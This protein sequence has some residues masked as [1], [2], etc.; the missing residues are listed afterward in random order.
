MQWYLFGL[1]SKAIEVFNYFRIF[2]ILDTS[3]GYY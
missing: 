2:T 1:I 3:I